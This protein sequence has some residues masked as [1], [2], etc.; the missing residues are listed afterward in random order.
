MTSNP[1]AVGDIVRLKTGTSPQRVIAVGRVNITAKYTS[2]GGHHYP[3]TTRHHDKFI[4]FEEPQM[5]QPTLFKTP[6]N[7]YGTLLARDS[8]GNMVLEL[9]G[10]VPKVQAYTPDQLEEVRPYTILVQAV[11][12]AR[13][14]FH[15]EAD[16]GSVEEGDLVFLPKHNTLIKIVKL[17]TKS[18]SARCRLKGIKLVG[19]PIAA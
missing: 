12:D 4:H 6:D 18:K 14:E 13:S 17:D 11:G 10:S 16:K 9:K 5:S 8:A 1:F 15:M 3:P 7:Q 19:E 2:P